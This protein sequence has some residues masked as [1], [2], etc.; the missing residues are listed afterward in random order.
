MKMR[1]TSAVGHGP[2]VMPLAP[3]DRL[4]LYR[5]CFHELDEQLLQLQLGGSTAEVRRLQAEVRSLEE[6]IMVFTELNPAITKSKQLVLL[7]IILM[8][9]LSFHVN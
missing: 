7:P 4:R 6:L 9:V 8:C 3:A 1:R 2:V 5:R